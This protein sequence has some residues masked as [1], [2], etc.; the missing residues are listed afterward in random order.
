MNHFQGLGE[1]T[2]KRCRRRRGEHGHGH[3]YGHGH[4]HGHGH[5]PEMEFTFPFEQCHGRRREPCWMKYIRKNQSPCSKQE[6]NGEKENKKKCK[7]E[8][9]KEKLMQKLTKINSKLNG[10]E[11]MK[12]EQAEEMNSLKVSCICGAS[13][14]QTTAIQAY[15]RC[16]QVV[17]DKCEQSCA[18]DEIIFH[19]PVKISARHPSGY[20]VCWKCATDQAIPS[21]PKPEEKEAK[22]QE[23]VEQPKI[24]EQPKVEQPKVEEPKPVVEPKKEQVN[25]PFANFT[26]ATE[27]RC[28]VD[29]GFNDYARIANL[30]VIKN[31]NI[32]EALAELLSQ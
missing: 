24:V 12:S 22:V 23:P 18:P 28:L 29:M 4:G 9:R 6:R 25:D 8:N 31:G 26:Y 19:C 20:D 1:I 2:G 17:C 10:R 21:E 14:V 3:G 13:L 27:A 5:A 15:R 11:E 16:P 32:E 7:L 30:L